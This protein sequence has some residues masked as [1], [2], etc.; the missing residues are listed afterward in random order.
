VGGWIFG[1][2]ISSV[3]YHTLHQNISI[4]IRETEGMDRVTVLGVGIRKSLQY[5]INGEQY[6]ESDVE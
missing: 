3:Y 2:N 4:P 5:I 6:D 1:Y